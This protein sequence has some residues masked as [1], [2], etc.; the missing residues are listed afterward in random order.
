MGF[1]RER[2]FKMLSLARIMKQYDIPGK[3]RRSYLFWYRRGVNDGI[4]LKGG[5]CR[6]ILL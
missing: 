2:F 6:G 1:N 4:Y 5:R 3:T